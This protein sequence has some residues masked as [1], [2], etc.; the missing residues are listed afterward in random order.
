MA[1][2]N[3]GFTLVEL[4][5]TLTLLAIVANIVVPAFDS[6][7]TRNRQQALM[8]QV[9]AVLSN[10]RAEAILQRRTIEICGSSDGKTCSPS[11]ANGWLVRVPN[12][13][14]M[15]ITQL[16]S[17]DTLRWSGFQQTIRFHNN[18]SSPISNGR[19]YQCHKQ[20]VAWQLVLNRQGRLRQATAA[21]N[22]DKASLCSP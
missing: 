15:Q 22:T 1:N 12:G 21:E 17:H 4:M 16:P 3:Q 7:I 18:G 2:R 10:A 20:K 8:E 6:L 5:I 11:W 9:A 14:V 19:F 13:R